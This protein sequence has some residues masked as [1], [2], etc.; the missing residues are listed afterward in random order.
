[1]L[2]AKEKLSAA[3]I[4]IVTPP[5]A[6]APYFGAVLRGLIRR[7]TPGLGTLGVTNRGV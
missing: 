1:M 4:R 7:E 5:V 6:T 2:S 3:I